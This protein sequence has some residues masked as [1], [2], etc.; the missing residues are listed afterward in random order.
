MAPE[1]THLRTL[2]NDQ[3]AILA[4]PRFVLRE[5]Q[6]S[7]S[8]TYPLKMLTTLQ[9]EKKAFVEFADYGWIIDRSSYN[10]AFEAFLQWRLLNTL[11]DIS[12]DHPSLARSRNLVVRILPTSC[13]RPHLRDVGEFRVIILSAGYLSAFK[14]FIRLWLRG[15]A[16]GEAQTQRRPQ[17]YRE[18]ALNYVAALEKAEDKMAKSAQ[19]YIGT[20]LQL[21]GNQVPY[22]D[23][24]SIFDEE[25][26]TRERWETQFGMLGNAIDG[27]VL[28][29]EAAHVLAGESPQTERTPASEVQA[30]RGA[31]SLCIIDEAR[32]GGH[33]TVHLGGPMYFCVELLRLL[34]E[35]ILEMKDGR[36]DPSVGRYPGIDE[37]MLRSQLYGEH[38]REFL[39]SLV[40][41]HYQEWS[42]AMGLVFDTVRWALLRTVGT[43]V[44]LMQFVAIP[45]RRPS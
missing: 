21:L 28:F 1:P 25:T 26:L 8:W 16:I 7:D 40:Y 31:V 43:Q 44:P 34:C 15:C 32:R 10:S 11:S 4:D 20:L 27:F 14:G 12:P 19:A 41:T 13:A 17:S 29:H 5:P 35:E 23:R 36:H 9:Q 37:L 30:D 3:L 39:G 22:M 2:I 42:H 18:F 33:G 38:V 24:E 45:D 6:E